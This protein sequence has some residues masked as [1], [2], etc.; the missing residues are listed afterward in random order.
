MFAVVLVK[1]TRPKFSGMSSEYLGSDCIRINTLNGNFWGSDMG[2]D[3]SDW[4]TVIWIK[5]QRFRSG[6]IWAGSNSG[7][8]M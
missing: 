7:Q 8:S 3:N 2:L 6:H 1:L 4:A 5:S